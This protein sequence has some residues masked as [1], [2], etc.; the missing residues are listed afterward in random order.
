MIE[1][2]KAENSWK[3]LFLGANQDAIKVGAGFGITSN[4]S[5][6]YTASNDGIISVMSSV[7]KN[8]RMYRSSKLSSDSLE[9][10]E[11]SLSFSDEQ[12]DSSLGK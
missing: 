4:N 5:V 10:A 1:T 12:R 3:F 7:N 8:M 2:L 9:D 6:T 11:S